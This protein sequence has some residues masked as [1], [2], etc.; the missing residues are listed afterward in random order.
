M[1]N[2]SLKPMRGC[3]FDDAIVAY[4]MSRALNGLIQQTGS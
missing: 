2:N 1:L 4:A 3:R